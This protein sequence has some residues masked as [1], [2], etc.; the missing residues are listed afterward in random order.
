MSVERRGS[1]R[2]VAWHGDG[3]ESQPGP[4][5]DQKWCEGTG[6]DDGDEVVWGPVRGD[7]R[8]EMRP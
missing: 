2:D 7:Y 8:G 3:L 1:H 4:I 6:N 5:S